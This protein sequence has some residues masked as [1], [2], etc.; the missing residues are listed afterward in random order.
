[1]KN[2]IRLLTRVTNTPLFISEDK[3]S[4]ISEEVLVKLAAG[5]PL[6][7]TWDNSAKMESRTISQGTANKIS[8][9]D[10]AIVNVHDSLASKGFAGL[11]GGTTYESIRNDIA[12][13]VSSGYKNIMLNIDSPGGEVTGLFALTQYIRDIQAAGTYIFSYIDGQATSAAFGIAAATKVRY[14]TSTSFAGSIAAIMVHLETSIA[15][16]TAGKTYTI[17]RSKEE[18]ALGDS[19]TPLAPDTYAKFQS[20]LDNMDAAFNNDV[21]MSMPNLTLQNLIDMKGSEFI[22]SEALQLGL[23]DSIVTGVDSAIIQAMQFKKS[24]PAVSAKGR[25]ITNHLQTRKGVNMTEEELQIALQA[26][27]TEVILLKAELPNQVKTA[28][29][30]ETARCLGIIQATASLKL[31]T[32]TA[33]KHITKGYDAE[34]SLEIQTEI[35][36]ATGAKLNVQGAGQQTTVDPDIDKKIDANL[37]DTNARMNSLRE[38]VSMAGLQLRAGV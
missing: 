6:N 1:M 12:A 3:L 2:Y 20:M 37:P 16:K 30:A 34:T 4:L 18:K 5:L 29:I 25:P 13:A 27:Q 11:S 7:T 14:A 19:H 23:V 32:E 10:I 22:A 8:S 31:S 36:E 33:I 17:F 21:L 24:K 28:V 9:S 15:D 26:S 38:G 35:A